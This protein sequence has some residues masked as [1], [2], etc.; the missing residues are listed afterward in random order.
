MKSR[1]LAFLMLLL[2][3]LGM[4]TASVC[5]PTAKSNPILVVDYENALIKTAD[6]LVMLQSAT[7]YGWDWVVTGLTSHSSNPSAVN[8]YGVTALGLLD[9]YQLT[10]NSAYFNAAKAVADYLVSL[11]SSRTHYQFDLE[12][13]I[14]FAEISGDGSYYTFALNVWAWMKANVDRY[15]DG[16]QVD[17]Y[18]YYYDRYG[19]SHG[20]ATWATGDWAIAALELGDNEWAKNMTDVIA[21]NYTKMEPDPQEYQYVGWGK[22]LK[23]FKA[24]NPTA[25]ADE[26]A[27]IVGILE[28]RQQPD[29]SFTGWIQDEAYLIMGLVSVGKMEMAKNASIWLINNQGYDTI[30]G[31]WKLPDGNEYSEVTSE[32]GQAIFRVIQAIGTVD[33]DHGS[34][35][36]IDVKTITIQQAINVAYAG[37]T[38]YVHSGLYNEALYIDKSLT[39]K[40]VGSPM[41]IIKGAQMRTTNYGNRQATIFVEDAANVTL[42]CFDIEG[43]ELGLPSG[44][45]SYAVLYESSTGMI[46]NCVVS[47]NTIGNMYST[48]IAFWDNSIV[49]VENSIIKNFGRIGIY[50]NNA[51]SIIKNNEIIGQ[52][53]SLDN[54]VIYGIEIEDYSGPSVAE[55]TGNKVYNC[56]NTH[57]SPLW[58]SAAILVDGWREWADYYNLA[59]LPSKVT[60]TYNTIYNNYESIEIVANEFSY[61]HY[62][63][64][65]NNAWGVISAPENWTT[66]PT[67][68]VFDARYN[69]WGD[70][71]GPYHETTW[72]YMGNPY[73]PHYGLGDPVSD[74]VLYDPWLKSAF[75][76]PP[77]HDVAVTS[78][79]VSNR[80]VLPADSGRIVLVGDVIQINVTVANE[81]NMVENF[82]VNVIVS[83]YDGVQVGVLPSQSV[84]ELVPSETRLLTFYW[85]TEGAETCGYIIRAIAS[86]VPGE[87]Y[88]DT[89][90]NTKAITVTVASYMP[91]IPKV[92]L[93]PA[94]KE[95]LVR[96]Y[97]DLNLNLEDADIFWDIGGFSVTIKFN[98]SIVQVTNVT[99]GSFLKSFGSTYSYWEIDNVEGYAVMYVTQLPPRST[100]YGS[101]TLFTIQFK[102]VGEGECNITMENSEL[103]AWPDESKWVF[104]YSVT[105]PHTTEDGYVKIMQPLP[106]DI[107]ADGQVSLADLVLLAKAYGSRPGDPNWNEYADIAEPWG[108][109]GLSDL[110]TIAVFYGQHFP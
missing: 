62:N 45:R 86:T 47:P 11:G 100:T 109:I 36:T 108:I 95:W 6:R 42:E 32:A 38:I 55:I 43:E 88:F 22:A 35:G 85:N 102:G 96:G 72:I 12:F 27:D 16:H 97:F 101:G 34:D 68:Y 60:I 107:N 18:N 21:A 76:P 2:M 82:A 89:F 99:E 70:A 46:R 73:G 28:T 10:G 50:S 74:Y 8:L 9:A 105:V 92:K 91:T 30:V 93:V 24:V 5:I 78:I 39:L 37:D 23:A 67:Y 90:D 13:L 79:M 54:Q 25:Y 44:T 63:N 1:S 33:V 58:S 26:I 106:A 3:L 75:V 15:A 77:R 48:A 64:F 41:P 110:V 7:D 29:G 31:G 104:I 80:M 66:N 83:R 98:P 87:K 14:I 52:V 84:I 59:L 71:S 4:F 81:G 94:Y 61:A 51:T 69:W 57:P 49:T 103:A 17:L 65:Y 40:G 56:N 20:G 53:Y 19:G